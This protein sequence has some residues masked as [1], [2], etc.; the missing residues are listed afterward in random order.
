[1]G[2]SNYQL[3]L[4]DN[5]IYLDEVIRAIPKQDTIG[6]V[7]HNLL[8]AEDSNTPGTGTI[9]EDCKNA[10]SGDVNCM[11]ELEDWVKVLQAIE[12]DPVLCNLQIHNV[13]DT[14]KTGFR[15][16][17][18][19]S[20]EMQ[21][22]V[23]IFRGTSTANEWIDNGEGGYL[24]MTNNQSMALDYVNNLDV[25]NN[26]SFVTSGHSKGGNLATF[27]TLFSEDT[28]ID[29]C[30]SF[31]GQGFSAELCYSEAYRD[32]IEKRGNNLYLVA[33]SC[34]Y[35]NVLFNSAV[36]EDH[37][38][39]LEANSV[40]LNAAGYHRPDNI[41]T[42]DE[43]GNISGLNG[44]T[45]ISATSYFVKGLIGYITNTEPDAENKK[46]IYNSLMSILA[47]T[48]DNSDD[49]ELA[50]G[51]LGK[52]ILLKLGTRALVKTY[53]G[54]PSV[55]GVREDLDQLIE[56]MTK[57]DYNGE[58][59]DLIDS[60]ALEL[61]LE[62]M[63]NYALGNKEGIIRLIGMLDELIHSEVLD[64]AVALARIVNDNLWGTVISMFEGFC[65][66]TLEDL[67]KELQ[68]TNTGMNTKGQ[69]TK[70]D[71][72]VAANDVGGVNHLG[73]GAANS[74]IGSSGDDYLHGGN[75]RDTV[76]GADGDDVIFGG[77][78][79]D[80]LYGH[81]GDDIYV[82]DRYDGK[83]IIYNTN[84]GKE[85][86]F[87]YFGS[88]INSSEVEYS[89]ENDN[90]CI[91]YNKDYQEECQV[92]IYNF[93]VLEGENL[94]NAVDAVMFEGGTVHYITDICSKVGYDGETGMSIFDKIK[95]MSEE[96]RNKIFEKYDFLE[97]KYYMEYLHTNQ[98][99]S[100]SGNNES[101]D[102]ESN[103]TT[104]TETNTENGGI[105]DKITGENGEISETDSEEVAEKKNN[106][107]ANETAKVA[108]ANV[109]NMVDDAR[110]ELLG[111]RPNRYHEAMVNTYVDPIVI[112][113]NGD[114][115]FTTSLEKGTHFDFAGD[116][117]AEKTAWISMGDALLVRDVNGNGL[118]DD[119]TE[120]F[121]DR[122]LLKDGS[123]AT[124]GFQALSDLD[125]NAD[126]MFDGQDSTYSQLRVWMDFDNNG[127]SSDNELYSLQEVGIIS[128]D[129][130]HKVVNK[131]DTNGNIIK[132]EGIMDGICN[133]FAINEYDFA[134]DYVDT[135]YRG[136][137]IDTSSI[138]E[139]YP[140]IKGCGTL[141]NLS[142]AM[143][144]N[145][146]LKTLVDQY[147]ETIHIDKKQ[148]L[149]QD[150]LYFEKA[151][152]LDNYDAMLRLEQWYSSLSENEQ[153]LF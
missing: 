149:V 18:F 83:D 46:L 80:M 100:E 102:L 73:N 108:S 143:A 42:T 95:E 82:I 68:Y 92:I 147:M 55:W 34:D 86:N 114:G 131:L 15:A 127:I 125:E 105:Y 53:L 54:T 118:I 17:T 67:K 65:E 77:R 47:A 35:V 58:A 78:G 1:M 115:I 88:G 144:I 72:Y 153:I 45:N 37:K 39:Y 135:E 21:E 148:A 69:G 134:I 124:S 126:G 8:Y 12:A 129:L 76:V 10:H 62:Y 30:L 24:P 117:F 99:E 121:G 87:I 20:E 104:E 41:F 57:D 74:I 89:R 5:L 40:G 130:A 22:N 96:E 140:E 13:E 51:A 119:G 26:Y 27:V 11:M 25:V 106:Y 94:V 120:L 112:D 142:Q 66:F 116:G 128:I 3:V 48:A 97:Y 2:L 70:G 50:T 61:M 49:M 81:A 93:F 145:D 63:S 122:T 43:D 146:N 7:V 32:A 132:A 31:D 29:R 139:D 14:G 98:G 91:K 75:G 36:P 6:R 9:F 103:D 4:L 28:L 84:D 111:K 150:I 101:S 113:L 123:I 56:E 90:L 23:I 44:A 137:N 138:G 79:N 107:A 64:E 110:N 33:S 133:S 71:I 16:A 38:M 152:E 60:G 136:E 151:K 19:I 52:K 85:L 141:L 109:R 59:Y